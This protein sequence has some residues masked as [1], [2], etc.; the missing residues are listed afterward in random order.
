MPETVPDSAGRYTKRPVTITA[1][2]WDGTEEQA[3]EIVGWIESVNGRGAA[4]YAPASPD[5]RIY[6]TVMEHPAHIFIGTLEGI[7]KAFPNYWII[8]GVKGEFYPCQPDIFLQSYLPAD[9]SGLLI[10]PPALSEPEGNPFPPR[11]AENPE[12]V[13][14]WTVSRVHQDDEAE[15]WV[16]RLSNGEHFLINRVTSEYIEGSRQGVFGG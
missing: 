12:L 1:V 16:L 11:S 10:I 2:Q 9:G 13:S 7:M 3:Q 5:T 8:Q 6:N 14:G 15:A 4:L